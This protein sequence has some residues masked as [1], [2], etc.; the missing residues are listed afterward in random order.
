MPVESDPAEL[1]RQ[2][3][4]PSNTRSF[5]RAFVTL[6]RNVYLLLL[7]TLG[8]GFQLSL[9]VLT[10]NYYVH[11]LGYQPDFI[12]IFSA[13]PALGSLVSAVPVGR[14]AD[15]L[16]RKP[17]LLITA[18]L[19]PLFLAA[20]GLVTSAPALLICA[21]LQGVVSTAYWVT[22][23]PLL[24]E[25]TTEEQRVGV[26]ALNS[27]LLLG[28]GALGS[29]LGGA[30]PEFVA[31]IAHV[32]AASTLPLRWGVIVAALFT[33]VFGLPLWL[34]QNPGQTGA[35][36]SLS[37]CAAQTATAPERWPVRLF[38]QLLL[39]DLVFT[40]GEGAVVALMQIYFVLRFHLLPGSLGLIFT[41]SGV[42][43]G[44]F[45]LTAPL[46][47]KRW[48]KLR[49]ITSVQYLTA[50]LML[51][52]GLAPVLPLAIGGEYMR[53]FMRTL[54]EPLYAAFALEQVSDRQRSTLAG[55][56]SVTWSLGFSIGPAIG[57]WLQSTVSLAMSF[58][59][60][61]ICLSIAPTLLLT[62]FGRKTRREMR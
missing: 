37:A 27:F 30:I 13:M 28:I 57:G 25:N 23:L 34:L 38:F 7:F 5:V 50:P 35:R 41:V 39:P 52:I 56:Y 17:V 32:S 21:F 51:L 11:S 18:V 48:S 4:G 46:F 26:L 58:V 20:C 9:S 15:R 43:S 61:A 55:L 36:Q 24:A 49:L 42:V 14:L 44:A 33:F 59:F 19:T 16:G 54:I 6:P 45:A 10:L 40:V 3:K 12:G 8:K 53:A 2:P 29:L 22:N 62:F 47:V 31:G 60:G 1:I